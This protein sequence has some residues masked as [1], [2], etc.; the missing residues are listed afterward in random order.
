[1]PRNFLQLTQTTMRESGVTKELTTVVAQTGLNNRFVQYVAD[2]AWDIETLWEDWNFMW[3]EFSSDTT[4]GNLVPDT[5]KPTDLG[6]YDTGSFVIDRTTA[7]YAKLTFMKY[8]EYRDGPGLGVQTNNKPQQIIVKPDDTLIAWPPSDQI[9]TLTCEYWKKPTRLALDLDNPSVP[10][11]YERII[12]ARAKTKYAAYHEAPEILNEAT[13]EYLELL[14]RLEAAYLPNRDGHR[15][16][17]A[18]EVITVRSE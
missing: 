15:Q 13:A 17:E 11:L 3:A 5:S 7:A 6:H 16:S 2:A 8:R 12:I 9:Y 18:V 1:M 4:I 10:D 14:D